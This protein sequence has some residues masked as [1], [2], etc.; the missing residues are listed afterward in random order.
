MIFRQGS[1]K[2]L[3]I[4]FMTL[5]ACAYV[6]AYTLN[7]STTLDGGQGKTVVLKTAAPSVHLSRLK[8]ILEDVLTQNGF[9]VVDGSHAD[10]ALMYGIEHKA[11]QSMVTVPVWGKTGINSVRT[12]SNGNLYGSS[13]GSMVQGSYFGNAATDVTYDYGVTGYHNRVVN[14]YVSAFIMV[15]QK[16]KTGDVVYEMILKVPDYENDANLSKF[17]EDVLGK[18][19]FFMN[20]SMELQCVING[21]D[22][23]CN[24]L[25]GW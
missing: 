18:Y 24:S 16:M 1:M 20:G 25:S 19:P 2:K 12:R 7:T 21:D 13:Y 17:V 8:Q 22:G 14:N 9:K 15:M 5:S 3:F 10:Y 4:F 6:P 11:W 23:S